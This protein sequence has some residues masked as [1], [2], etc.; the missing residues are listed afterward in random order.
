[1]IEQLKEDFKN[2]K[3]DCMGILLF[4]S[5]TKGEQTMKSDVD[6]CIVKPS[7]RIQRF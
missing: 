6:V 3:E 7:N 1:M 5:H 2:F 4:G